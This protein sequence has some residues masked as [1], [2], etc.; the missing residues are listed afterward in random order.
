L[1][2]IRSLLLQ[3]ISII[4]LIAIIT[5]NARIPIRIQ[6]EATLVLVMNLRRLHPSFHQL[7]L[8]PPLLQV[9]LKFRGRHATIRP[10]RLIKR[11]SIG[12]WELS[13]Q[14]VLLQA[15]PQKALFM[16]RILRR[17]PIPITRGTIV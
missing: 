6:W 7:H 5:I 10:T 4:L 1:E 2:T 8:M 11:L 15:D 9:V 12:H 16:H 17:T 3:T 13:I 14:Q